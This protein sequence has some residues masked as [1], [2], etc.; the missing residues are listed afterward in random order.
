MLKLGIIGA[1][2]YVGAEIVRLIALRKDIEITTVVSNSFAGKP[3]SSVYPSLRGIFDKTCDQLDIEE[4]SKKAD[5]F[6]T[7]LPHGVS[8]EIVPELLA[9]GKRVIDHSGDFRFRDIN[10]YEKWYN[11]THKSPQLVK[12]AVYGLPEIY[13]EKI[14][15][16]SLVADPGCYPTCSILAIAPALAK[17]LISPKGIIIDAVS[18]VSGAGRKSDLYYSYCETE[19]NFKAYGVANHRH[20]PE[21]EQELSL[22]ADQEVLI[23]FTPHLAPMKRG[24]MTTCYL[25][26]IQ[27]GFT[28]SNVLEIY[29]EYYENEPFIRVLPEGILPETKNVA[30][31]NFVDIGLIVDKRLN[32]LIVISALDNLGKGSASQAVQALNLMAGFNETEGLFT[33]SVYI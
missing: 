32:K 22:L 5:F 27:D 19:A 13:R 17:K 21:I 7:A 10:V 9:K 14:K 15:T 2:G 4:V 33:P 31:S 23:S 24:M 11:I 12:D 8:G 25:D 1:T 16:A 26:L 28:T 29:K 6:I 30:G 20:T 3:Y 18:G